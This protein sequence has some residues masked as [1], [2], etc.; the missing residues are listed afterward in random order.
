MDLSNI[1]AAASTTFLPTKRWSDLEKNKVFLVTK[2]KTANTK[3][4][5]KIVLELDYTFQ[6][7][8]LSRV[9]TMIENNPKLH[10]DLCEAI[11][12]LQLFIDH[13]E[14]GVFEFKIE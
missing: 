5:K 9:N 7:F 10:D 4:G 6:L 11:Q 13:S 3:Y 8:S 14:N 1:N 2:M 12:K